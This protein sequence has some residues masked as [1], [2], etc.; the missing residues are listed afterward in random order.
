MRALECVSVYVCSQL[1]ARVRRIYPAHYQQFA[2]CVHS[3]VQAYRRFGGGNSDVQAGAVRCDAV[4]CVRARWIKVKCYT[5]TH[6][7]AHA[8]VASGAR[9]TCVCVFE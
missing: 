4:R 9:C 5:R 6:T 2:V 3:R 8:Q 1:K 7:R